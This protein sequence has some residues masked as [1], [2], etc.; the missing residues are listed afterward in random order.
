MINRQSKIENLA[1]PAYPGRRQAGRKSKAF[2]SIERLVVGKGFTLIELLV[3]IAIISL[4]VSILLP[5]LNRAKDLAK[6]V[7]CANNLKQLGLAFTT[8]TCEGKRLPGMYYKEADGT[9][10]WWW[11][12]IGPYINDQQEIMLCP[13]RPLSTYEP[14]ADDV[15]SGYGYNFTLA[16]NKFLPSRRMTEVPSGSQTCL[17]VD[18]DG[19]PYG[20]DLSVPE[21]DAIDT[22]FFPD[23][24]HSDGANIVFCDGHTEWHSDGNDAFYA[25]DGLIDPFN[26]N[27]Y[28]DTFWWP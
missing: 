5:S 4:L 14:T 2:T 9:E 27:Y 1:Y 7:V 10:I 23:F 19:G 24:R 12:R 16:Y 18:N 25:P 8:Y 21:G 17:L 13:N 15:H 11:V 20:V 3:V 26:I 6:Q 28:T 22:R